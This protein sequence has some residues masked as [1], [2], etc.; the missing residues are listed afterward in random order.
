MSL[1]DK[2][3]LRLPYGPLAIAAIR[4]EVIATA[5]AQN[6]GY[7]QYAGY[8]DG[9]EWFVVR[10]TKTVKTKMGVAFDA[11]EITLARWSRMDPRDL[12]VVGPRPLFVT[13]YSIQ[14]RINTSVKAGDVEQLG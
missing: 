14:N 3:R 7:P 11:G 2:P 12:A 1:N 10:I 13:A 6:A 8:W 4:H 9:P 5:N